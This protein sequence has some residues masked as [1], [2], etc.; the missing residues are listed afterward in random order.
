MLVALIMLVGA[1]AFAEKKEKKGAKVEEKPQPVALVSGSD[2]ISYAAGYQQVNGLLDFLIAQKMDTAYMADFINGMREA[3]EQS[4]NPSFVARS[5][6]YNIADQLSQRMIPGLGNELK[7]SPDSLINEKFFAGF[8]AS[9]QND[10]THYT[11]QKATNFFQSRLKQD[12]EMKKEMQYGANRKAGETFLAENAKK[13]GV[14]TTP[15]GLQYKVIT[16]GTGAVP[17]KD[18]TVAVK[19]EGKLI[20][21]TVFDSSYKR[22]DPITKFRCDQV[23]KGWTEA[24]TMMPVGSTWELYIPYNLAYGDRDAG[25]IPPYSC[26]IFKVEL[27]NIEGVTDESKSG[28]AV[29]A[30]NKRDAKSIVE[31]NAKKAAAKKPVAKKK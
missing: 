26:L 6:G 8:F 9:L 10:T 24:L 17:Q 22:Q 19:Y 21:G 28:D 1:T 3:I 20:D 29:V 12:Q 25:K 27:I 31:S 23:I 18:Q 5:L 11:M 15:S 7:G 4:E 14:V 2:S 13:E 16:A 30:G